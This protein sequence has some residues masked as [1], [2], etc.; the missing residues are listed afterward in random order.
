MTLI[1]AGNQLW[2][3]ERRPDSFALFQPLTINRTSVWTGGMIWAFCGLI[4]CEMYLFNSRFSGKHYWV[5]CALNPTCFCHHNVEYHSGSDLPAINLQEQIIPAITSESLLA[6]FVTL[7]YDRLEVEENTCLSSMRDPCVVHALFIR[8]LFHQCPGFHP[9]A[10]QRSPHSRAPS[11]GHA[12]PVSPSTSP[13]NPQ[14][15]GPQVPA[16][17][18]D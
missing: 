10:G 3:P 12:A 14:M 18:A 17:R 5:G 6:F 11:L 1:L 15:V 2:T 16:I 9:N 13:V 8:Y 4:Q 7:T